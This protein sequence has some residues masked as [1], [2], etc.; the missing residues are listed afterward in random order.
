MGFVRL[1][2][3]AGLVAGLA[4]LAAGRAGAEAIALH[5]E[6][7]VDSLGQPDRPWSV[8]EQRGAPPLAVQVGDVI[9]G[10][11][12]FDPSIPFNET[13]DW[14]QATGISLIV[15][16]ELLQAP[17]LSANVIN[18]RRW[19]FVTW[20]GIYSGPV[21]PSPG[22]ALGD[23]FAP[24]DAPVLDN[25][26]ALT[27]YLTLDATTPET[28]PWRWQPT[29]E[30]YGPTSVLELDDFLPTEVTAWNAFTTKTLRFGMDTWATLPDGSSMRDFVTA[31]ATISSFAPVPE[32]GSAV[33]AGAAL[34]SV[35]SVAKRRN[36]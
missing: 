19:S 12:F 9:R 8:T 14:T 23:R 24:L 5:F 29:I 25:H 33:C 15:D 13:T 4:G 30:L 2:L 34:L 16:G 21:V 10:S 26:I 17:T 20:D 3:L 18:D 7:T 11:L 35:A 6:A 27:H 28:A 36:C 22:V 32:P 1:G 31:T